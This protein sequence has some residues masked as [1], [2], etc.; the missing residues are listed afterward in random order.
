LEIAIEK[1]RLTMKH[2]ICHIVKAVRYSRT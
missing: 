1:L 2:E